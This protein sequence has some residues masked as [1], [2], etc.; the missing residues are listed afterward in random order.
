MDIVS[1]ARVV[2]A[3]GLSDGSVC[4]LAYKHKCVD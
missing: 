2:I 4:L 3:S 1:L